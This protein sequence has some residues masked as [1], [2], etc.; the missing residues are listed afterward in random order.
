LILLAAGANP[1]ALA[2][3]R[4]RVPPLLPEAWNAFVSALFV[5]AF[6]VLVVCWLFRAKRPE[7]F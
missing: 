3:F 4:E 7:D 5:I 1:I 2:V 6:Q